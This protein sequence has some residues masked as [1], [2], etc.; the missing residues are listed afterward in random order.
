MPKPRQK[1]K[2]QHDDCIPQER[3][4]KIDPNQF[5]EER[6]QLNTFHCHFPHTCTLIV[7]FHFFESFRCINNQKKSDQT[8]IG[9]L[10]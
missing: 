6:E 1:R 3:R 2:R 9:K 10:K 8:D 7:I 4:T 5:F